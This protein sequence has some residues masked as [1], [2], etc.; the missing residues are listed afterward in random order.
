VTVEL[1]PRPSLA[2]SR[3][4]VTGATGFI[5]SHVARALLDSGAE[6]HLV[7]RPGAHLERVPD[8]GARVVVHTDDGT[9]E[10]MQA[11]VGAAAPEVTFHLATNFVAEHQAGDVAGFVQDNVGFPARLADAVASTAAASGA[12]AVFVNVGTCWQHVEGARYR[13]KSLYAATKQAFEDVLVFYADRGL[14]RT[15]T[16]N[17][18]DSYGP[19]DHRAK[20]LGALVRALQTGD[21]LQMSSGVQLIDLVH[22]DDIVRA[23][24]VAATRLLAGDDLVGEGPG[25]FAVS[26]G[27]P[28]T[29]R[30]LVDEIG[31]VAGRPVLVEWGARPD[32]AG[33]MV[34]HWDAGPPV[35]GWAPAIPLSDGLAQLLDLAGV[36]RG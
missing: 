15:A 31:R 3:A 17:V 2:V 18:F 26:S 4:L 21:T 24:F 16:V 20:L 35:P 19:L 28:V 9:I 5:G 30:G 14:L 7:V 36:E 6:V 29:L 27:A 22:V 10:G 1:P 25:Y 23:L 34:E 11:V 8:L 13:P 33:D 12:G 32:R